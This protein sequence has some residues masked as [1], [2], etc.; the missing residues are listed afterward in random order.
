MPPRQRNREL[1]NAYNNAR[2]AERRAF[3]FKIV[4]CTCKWC[5]T[6][7]NLTLDH[8][9]RYTKAVESNRLHMVSEERF[10]AEIPKLQ[11][12]CFECHAWK[13]N[14]ERRHS[15]PME[16]V[17]SDIVW[18]EAPK[19]LA[20]KWLRMWSMDEEDEIEF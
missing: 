13:S 4:G 16:M 10:R 19:E 14:W 2:Y 17:W 18:G 6:S 12:L 20:E 1:V 3:A 9:D 8:I 11:P 7:E 15:G 5:G